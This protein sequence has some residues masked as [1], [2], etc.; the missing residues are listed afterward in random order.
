VC[1][2]VSASLIVN[3][4]WLCSG[5]CYIYYT[6][7]PTI[8]NANQQRAG[9]AIVTA[10]CASTCTAMT[11]V[12]APSSWC[13]WHCSHALSWFSPPA[14]SS[15]AGMAT[16][17]A[18]SPWPSAVSHRCHASVCV[19]AAALSWSPWMWHSSGWGAHAN[20]RA[21]AVC[22]MLLAQLRS[23]ALNLLVP[24]SSPLWPPMGCICTIAV[25]PGFELLSLCRVE[26]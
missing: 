12:P 15:E 14:Q 20:P 2:D 10:L 8:L 25:D 1:H 17:A 7:T 22:V 13:D 21:A 5:A 16:S 6:A 4:G 11:R 26:K 9:G 3:S 23:T 19:C 24:L 18:H